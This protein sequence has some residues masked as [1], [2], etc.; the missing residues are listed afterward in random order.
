[1][2]RFNPKKLNEIEGNLQ[3]HVEISNRFAAL[4]NLD[5]GWI[6]L[7]FGKLLQRI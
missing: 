4:K 7:E 5:T 1:M 2:E 6:I 3:H